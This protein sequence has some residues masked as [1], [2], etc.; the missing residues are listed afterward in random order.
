LSTDQESITEYYLLDNTVLREFLRDRLPEYMVPQVWQHLD[1][2]PLSSNGKTDRKTLARQKIAAERSPRSP[3][4]P[5]TEKERLLLGLW[6]EAL[7]TGPIGVHDTFAELGGHSLLALRLM[8]AIRKRFGRSVLGAAR[9]F[10]ANLAAHVRHRPSTYPG[11]SR[12]CA[13]RAGHG[14]Q[15]TRQ[16]RPLARVGERGFTMHQLPAGHYKLMR[17]PYVAEVADRVNQVLGGRR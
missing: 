5:A 9:V 7:G 1:E 6:E 10:E 11:D 16:R 4:G 15:R 2:I 12:R 17:P 3:V 14:E 8:A 13:L